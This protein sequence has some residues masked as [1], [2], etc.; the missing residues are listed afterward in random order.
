[1]K[2]KIPKIKFN[3]D[4]ADFFTTHGLTFM[5]PEI[6][7]DW[8]FII[9]RIQESPDDQTRTN[10]EKDIEALRNHICWSDHKCADVTLADDLVVAQVVDTAIM[11]LVE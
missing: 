10:I 3:V 8:N 1:M 7:D 5:G 6:S 2:L 11:D 9:L 4:W